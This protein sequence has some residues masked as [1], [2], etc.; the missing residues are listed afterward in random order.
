MPLLD[1]LLLRLR[2]IWAPVGPAAGQPGVPE[3]AGAGLETEIAD[4]TRELAGIDD[5]AAAMVRAAEEQAAGIRAAGLAEASRIG[6][7]ARDE[8]PAARAAQAARRVEDRQA[9]IAKILQAAEQ[10]AREVRARASARMPELV[11]R[12][13]AEVFGSVPAKEDHARLVGGG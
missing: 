1:D 13:T 9:E 7:R 4:L 5:E 10:A 11:G 12:V 6:E 8:L 2:R 3:E